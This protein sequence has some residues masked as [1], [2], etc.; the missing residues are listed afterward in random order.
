MSQSYLRQTDKAGKREMDRGERLNRLALSAESASAVEP[1]RQMRY[2]VAHLGWAPYAIEWHRS[3]VERH[4]RRGFDVLSFCTVP[5]P[6]APRYSFQELDTLWRRR[7]AEVVRLHDELVEIASDCDVLVNFNGA[8]IHPDWLKDLPTFNVYI[9]WDDPESSAE[10][11]QPVAKYFDFAFTGNI[12]CIPL[13]Q[14]WGIE[15]CDYLPFAC[16][17][18]DYDHSMTVERILEDERDID[19]VFLGERVSTW[20][21]TRLDQLRTAFPEALMCGPGWPG[22]FLPALPT[23]KRAKIGLNVHNS[24][25]PVN[26]RTFGLPAN[27]VMQICDNKCRL[28]QIF[29]LGREVIGY[30]TIEECIELTRYYLAHDQERREIAARGFERVMSDYT[31]EKQWERL[32]TTIAPYVTLKRAD[33]LD[34]PAYPAP[35]VR[36]SPERPR[37]GSA[38]KRVSQKALRQVGLEIR[39]LERPIHATRDQ[40]ADDVPVEVPYVENQEVGPVNWAEKSARAAAGQPLEWPNMVAL[41]WA[42]ATLVGPWR[43]IVELGGG[44]G[45]FA[46]EVAADPKRFVL[47]SD[48]DKHA[49]SW[50][51]KNRSRPNIRYIDHS[52]TADAGPFDV[53][54]AIDVIEHIK[55]YRA[56]LETCV[57]LACRAIITT[58]NKNRDPQSA[59][60][61]PPAYYQHV[62]EWTAGEFYWVLR[63]FYQSVKLYA[64]PNVRVPQAV[65]ICISDALTPL[66][67]VCEQPYDVPRCPSGGAQNSSYEHCNR[68]YP[69]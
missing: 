44:T 9:C 10:L 5:K 27:G 63:T 55:D 22:G 16:Y 48:P 52:P 66:I 13:Y 56:F 65:P 53:V 68:R 42:T 64:L 6:P 19:I 20:R 17:E 26:L 43:R 3:I 50:A 31:E 51:K 21:R 61:S 69:P 33:R 49:I 4:C 25:G 41:N 39:R 7:D 24:V 37:V 40:D 15:R 2:L 58:P 54:V 29:E 47:C 34:T 28:G 8:N 45:C 38:M 35:A 32:L 12:A 60:A 67:A 46:Y 1:M 30:D 11:S 59:I 62:R 14:S 57:D 36:G 23:Y 18:S